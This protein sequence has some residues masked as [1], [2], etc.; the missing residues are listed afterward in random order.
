MQKKY[1]ARNMLLILCVALVSR[2]WLYRQY[3]EINGVSGIAR[4]IMGVLALFML[5]MIIVMRGAIHKGALLTRGPYRF[6]A[7]PAYIVYILLD[8]PLWFI[9]PFS[10]F[11]VTSGILFYLVLLITAYLEEVALIERFGTEA[12]RYYKNTL[13]LH[14]FLWRLVFQK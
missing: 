12:R 14:F 7:H 6:V 1:A 10:L 3:F 9:S 5:Y 13:S 2:G 8:I 11:V 4:M